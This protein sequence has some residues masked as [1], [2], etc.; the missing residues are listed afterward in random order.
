MADR[1]K[2]VSILS[3]K[4]LVKLR[5]FS[6]WIN[7]SYVGMRQD[8]VNAGDTAGGWTACVHTAPAACPVAL[9][10]AAAWSRSRHIRGVS[11]G[12]IGTYSRYTGE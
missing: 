2:F 7:M 5:L 1:Q 9:P 11:V 8:A 6:A 4:K 10:A 12:I 3:Q